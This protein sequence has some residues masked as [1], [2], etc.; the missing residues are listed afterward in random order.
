MGRHRQFDEGEAL[1]AALSVFWQKGYEGASFEDLSQA[2]GVAR[3]GLYSAFGNKEALFIKAL[4]LY[5]ARYMGFMSEALSEPTSL[6]VV[7]RILQGSANIHTMDSAH[8]GCL[9]INGAL[10]CSDD[11]EPIR[12]ELIRRRA[13]TQLAL[14]KR[15]ERA[16]RE[17]ELPASVDG[18][19]LA[20]FVMAISQGMAVQAKAGASKKALEGLVEYV[21]KTWPSASR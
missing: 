6:K 15:L 5:D 14:R 7:E 12:R 4:D 1:E 2:T 20:S 8:P 11:A 10:A 19:T 3:P 21:I 16:Q 18:A 9:G 13:A 17:G